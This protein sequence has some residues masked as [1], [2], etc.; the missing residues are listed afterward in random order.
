MSKGSSAAAQVTGRWEQSSFGPD[1]LA[2]LVADGLVAE[3]DARIPRVE[4]VPAPL[5]DEQVC[6]KVFSLEG[7]LCLFIPLF[8]D[9]CL[10]MGFSCTILP[11]MGCFT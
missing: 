6:S 9:F 1:D 4:D 8:A 11:P 7:S 5:V 2:A 3:G 10:C